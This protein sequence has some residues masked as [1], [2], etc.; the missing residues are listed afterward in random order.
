MVARHCWAA[1][2][3]RASSTVLT[4]APSAPRAKRTVSARCSSTR[5]PTR[6][7]SAQSYEVSA[8]GGVAL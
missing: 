8:F 4:F 3:H 2:R 7:R 6:S 5:T 1:T